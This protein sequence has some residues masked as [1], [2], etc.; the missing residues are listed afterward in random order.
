MPLPLDGG[1][2]L[3]SLLP[4]SWATSFGKLE[5]F[6]LP[7]LVILLLTGA[8]EILLTPVFLTYIIAGGSIDI[9]KLLLP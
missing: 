8:L 4:P 3:H 2:V 6:G 5:P 1:R 9:L 7:I